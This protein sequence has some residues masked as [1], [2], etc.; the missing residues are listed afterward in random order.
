VDLK[1]DLRDPKVF[2]L[3]GRM[4]EE[5]RGFSGIS[6][7]RSYVD[8]I[9]MALSPDVVETED[10][11]VL[12]IQALG[13][14]PAF[15]HE[16]LTRDLNRACVVFYRTREFGTG[17]YEEFRE[18]IQEY[19]K[20]L[21][22]GSRMK[23]NGSFPMFYES[24]TLISQTLALSLACSLGMI[25]L[26]LIVVLKSFRL[27]LLCLIPNA[28]PLLVVSGITGWLGESIHLG[29]LIVFSVGLGLAVD[30]TIHLMVRFKQ[31]QSE[32]P[33]GDLRELMNNALASTGFA[34]IL[35]SLVLL[36]AAMCFLGSSFTTMRW[37]GV[38]LGIVA[39]TAL[40]ADLIVLPWLVEKCGH[41][42][43]MKNTAPPVSA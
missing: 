37:T 20:E 7:S 35:T 34:I 3:I 12:G 23:L 24:T 18:K 1:A 29:I 25:T 31:L 5:L 41:A 43:W 40:M 2:A 26:I 30:D 10:G 33:E 6:G 11:P 28:I 8:A 4:Q 39:I 38:T 14:G 21:P 17:A 22:A 32:N 13:A 19:A 16:L 42:R 36:L 9:N 15:P 27:A